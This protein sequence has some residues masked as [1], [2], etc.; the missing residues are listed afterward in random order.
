MPAPGRQDLIDAVDERDVLVRR[1]PRTAIFD[2]GLGFRVAHVF[3]F[4]QRGALLL[5]RL[6]D[7]HPRHPGL[8]GSSVA[9][10]LHAGET[11]GEAAA[12]RQQE[13]LGLT[14]R[15]QEIGSTSMVDDGCTKFITLFTGSAVR[16]PIVREPGHVAEVHFF[17]I[18]RVTSMIAQT[19]EAF[20]DTFRVVFDFFQ[21]ATAEREFLR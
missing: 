7:E 19:P 5:Q 4:N 10:Y 18:P 9:A 6:G 20:T 12:R 21:R 17:A 1:V 15:L 11:Y 2:S 16:K 14:G 13:E 3:L 8:W